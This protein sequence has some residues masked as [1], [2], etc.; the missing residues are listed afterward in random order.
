MLLTGM[1]LAACGGG[2]SPSSS[3]TS[4][5]TAA[6]VAP[7]VTLGATPTTITAGGTATLTWSSSNATACTASGGWTGSEP[8]SG[9]FTIAGLRA[10]TSYTLSC[11]GTS[12]D[13]TAAATATVTVTAASAP[14][15]TL[16]ANPTSVQSGGTSLLTWTS[17]NTT[18]CTASGGWSGSEPTSGSVMT[19]A[20]NAPTSYTLRCTGVGGSRSVSTTVSITSPGSFAV[21]PL[22]AALTLSQSQQFTATVPGGGNATWSVDGTAGGNATV[23]TISSSGLYTPPSTPGIH[24]IVATG[25]VDPTQGGSATVAVTDLPGIYT[26]HDDLARTGQNLQEYALTPASVSS[27]D[28]GRIFSCP[29]DGDVYA[30]PLYVAN[31][32]IGGGV[33]NVVFIATQHDSVYAFDADSTGCVTYW[34]ISEID[35][36]A[37]VTTI[38]ISDIG[39]GCFDILTEYGITGTPVI[40]PNSQTLYFVANTKEN[41]AY[42]QRLHAVSLATGAEQPS[43][44]VAIQATIQ[45]N[46]G[47]PVNFSPLW[48]NQRSGLVLGAGNI[49]IGWAAHCDLGD[50]NQNDNWWGWLM[51]YDATTL[52]QTAVFNST[53]NNNEGG[54]WMSGGAPAMDSAGNMYFSTGNGGFDDTGN[55]PIPPLA[56]N[57]DFGMSFL[58]LNAAT[59]TVQDFYTPSMWQNW[60]LNDEDISASG[61]TVLPDGIG[62]SGH[63]NALVGSDKQGHLWLMDRNNLGGFNAALDNTVQYLTLPYAG[64]C[65]PN[66]VFATPGY[67][68]GSGT[69][70]LGINAGPL[71]ALPLQNGL[72]SADGLNNAI[73]ASQSTETYSYPSPTPMISASPAGNAIV[74]VLDNS[75]NGTDTEGP[76]PVAPAILRAYDAADLS[77]TLYDS[78]LL[79]SDQGGNAVKFQ[80][81]VVANGRV[82]VGGSH[83]LT[84]Y[85]LN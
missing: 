49:Y 25:V 46:S 34:Q 12:G 70:Y 6:S 17:T 57:N 29:V 14:T 74:W 20:L 59:L 75:G 22:N 21:S 30:Q 47:T 56:P 63:P 16:G 83:Q 66:C 35:P 26:Y 52:A 9:S 53:P 50:P 51:S 61:V 24:L 82:Y 33:H 39:Q 84:V 58:N 7:S 38:P 67:Y 3:T 40:D 79:P 73:S 36:L 62:P 54:I 2:S 80:M 28:F 44:P 45:T 60:S 27:G 13:T 72:F 18:A 64:N 42:F 32:T 69:V 31:L 5:A 10:T 55:P 77:T 43:S 68:S 15:V 41:G 4:S 85:G 1:M 71:L 23:G 76:Q 11:T 19:G 65:D 37:G 8:T 78:S 48:E 81:P